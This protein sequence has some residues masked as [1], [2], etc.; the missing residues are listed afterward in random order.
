MASQVRVQRVGFIVTKNRRLH[1]MKLHVCGYVGNPHAIY[2]YSPEL[3]MNFVISCKGDISA[4]WGCYH[5]TSPIHFH[6]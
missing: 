5:N 4:N 6:S 3:W 2:H 1:K